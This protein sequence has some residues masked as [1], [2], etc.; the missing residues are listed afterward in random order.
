MRIEISPCKQWARYGNVI[1]SIHRD[2][3]PEMIASF[4]L[5]L[6]KALPGMTIKR[7]EGKVDLVMASG[8][9]FK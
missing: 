2:T 3:T 8:D 6:E 4:F 1:A 5:H 7:Y 9:R